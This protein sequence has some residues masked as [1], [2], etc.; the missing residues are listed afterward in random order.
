MV[1]F[2]FICMGVV[3]VSFLTLAFQSV[4][5][6]LTSA[7][8]EITARN[9]AVEQETVSVIE[10]PDNTEG[11]ADLNKIDTAAGFA[12]SGNDDFG[13]GFTNTAPTAL[14]EPTPVQTPVTTAPSTDAV[15]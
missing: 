11:A 3:V 8:Q 7:Q 5:D 9:E 2:I 1:R 14:E 13:T 15:N 10:Q 6:G 4:T 12:Q